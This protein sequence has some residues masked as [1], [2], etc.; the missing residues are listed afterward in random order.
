VSRRSLV[1]DTD[2]G[3]DVDDALALAFALRHP[4]VELAAVTTVSGDAVARARIAAKL[5]RLAGRDD[6][7][8]APGIGA[9]E[10]PELARAWMGHEG[11]GLLEP[12]ERVPISGRSA[13]DVLLTRARDGSGCDV[14]TVG[15]QT[16]VAAALERDSGLARGVDRLAV[17]GG[18]F[19][20]VVS[21]DAVLDASQDHNLR[22]DPD[23]ALRT[24]NAGMP[25][26]YVPL[27][28]TV[29]THLTRRQQERLGQGDELCR[30][31]ARLVDVWTPVLHG[32]TGGRLPADHV[33]VMH[34]PLTVAVLVDES[35]VSVEEMPVSAV[36]HEGEVRT[37]VDPVAGRPAR[38]VTSVAAA[39][40]A[41]FWLQT[42]LG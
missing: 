10:R 20:R 17:M 21:G 30:A 39:E 27:D 38:V 8:V 15:M 33:A 14:A 4:N 34:D 13:V 5:T 9:A 22:V 35:F 36:L 37:F 40:F 42:V 24:L 18:L 3:T 2:I 11:R 16:N 41:D 6:V 29:Q 25:V 19:R 12:D 26:L 28:V 7:E 23:A 31:L 1:L 32:L